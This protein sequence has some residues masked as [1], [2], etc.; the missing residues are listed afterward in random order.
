MSWKWLVVSNN[1]LTKDWWSLVRARWFALA[2][3]KSNL[4][5]DRGEQMK[6]VVRVDVLRCTKHHRP[7]HL[8]ISQTKYPLESNL[9]ELFQQSTSWGGSPN[10]SSWSHTPG[11]DSEQDNVLI[12]VDKNTDIKRS[13]LILRGISEHNLLGHRA[14][15][16]TYSGG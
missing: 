14:Q 6:S 11:F 8:K 15:A 10:P 5:S 16:K 3:V 12:L 4:E 13:Y 9:E 1:Y 2:L 7:K